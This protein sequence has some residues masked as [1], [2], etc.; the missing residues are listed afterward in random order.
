MPASTFP[1][2]IAVVTPGGSSPLNANT[3][4]TYVGPPNVSSISPGTGPS[5]TVVTLTG[6]NF[7]DATAVQ[8]GTAN[9]VWYNVKNDSTILAKAP[10]GTGTVDI[11]V[12]T[13]Y[14]TSSTSSAD[15]FTY[16]VPVPPTVTSLLP[17]SGP[18]PGGTS[19]TITGTNFTGATAVTFGVTAATSV[20]VNSATSITATS[21]AGTGTVDVTVTTPGGTS[22]TGSGDQ[23]TYLSTPTVS[24]VSPNG[25]PPAG[26]TTVT[27]T[28]TNL[29][30]ATAA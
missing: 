8:F 5:G 29:T 3:I 12:T 1:V 13:A 14:G 4:F 27:I 22:A 30:G 17:T 20:T 16:L 6:G 28:G 7:S 26:G 10:A 21:P 19:V 9:A 23:F 15:Q 25:G 11:T 24:A 2:S 18:V